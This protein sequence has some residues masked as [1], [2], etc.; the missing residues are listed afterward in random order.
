MIAL[1]LH[2]ALRHAG[3][4]IAIAAVAGC[5]GRGHQ[6]PSVSLPTVA[7]V[8]QRFVDAIGGPAAILR[9]RSMTI[10]GT[11]TIYAAHGRQIH[12][13]IVLYLADFKRL[14]IVTVPH[15]GRYLSGYDG[16]IGWSIGTHSAAQVIRG[17]NAIS[18]RRDADMYYFAHIPKYFKSMEVVGVESFAGRRCYHLRGITLWGNENNQYYDVKSGLLAGYRFHQWA[19]GTPE[20]AESRQVFERYHRFGKLSLATR[21]TDFKDDKLVGVGRITSVTYDNVNPNVFTPPAAV[22]ALAH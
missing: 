22:R 3:V 1:Q 15:L 19:N 10:R 13:G 2:P 20:I 4:A 21:E 5:G 12:A 8:Q 9:A 17:H 11:N 6:A 7:Q 14:E 18:I 16:K